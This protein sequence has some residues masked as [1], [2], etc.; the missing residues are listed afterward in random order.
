MDNSTNETGFQLERRAANG[1]WTLLR[2]LPANTTSF[3]D[4]TAL[5]G[6][7]Y[8]YHI[9]ATSTAGNSSWATAT[10]LVHTSVATVNT[11]IWS[12]DSVVFNQASSPSYNAYVP[13][14]FTYYSA[15]SS[16]PFVTGQTLSTTFRNNLSA[17]QGMKITV[18]AAPI[19][20]N[21]LGRWVISGNAGTHTLKLVDAATGVDVPGG[22]VSVAMAGATAGQFQYA[23]LAAP[24]TLAA[25]T[26]YYLVS[27]E[28]SGG[29]QWYE[30]NSA[31]TFDTSMATTQ[32]VSTANN[33][34]NWYLYN[35]NCSFGPLSFKYSVPTAF[36]TG[37]TMTA[38]R[39]DATGWMG[40]KIT[41]GT[42]DLLLNQLGRWVVPGNSGT[43]T[44]KLVN[45]TT[46]VDL[47]SATVAT[48]GATSGQFQYTPLATPIT[49]IASN[50][51]YLLSQETA[52]G[53]QWYDF[54]TPAEGT[55]TGYQFWLLANGLPMDASA[56]GSAAATPANDSLPNLIKYALGLVPNVGGNGGRLSYG[57]VTDTGNNYLS[58]T[59][60][61]PEPA[62][63]GIT[64]TVE[65]SP[66]L[67]SWTTTGLVQMS[68][69]VSASFCTITVRNATP[70]TAGNK[71]FMRLR[72]TQP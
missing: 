4:T 13:T 63:G 40:M 18:K 62:P 12:P 42:S 6:V 59:Y 65:S 26:A 54:A 64:Y 20:I 30:A 37:H 15:S 68:S 60:S 51:Y 71:S 53:D 58:L 55:A 8:E 25:N 1:A 72:T 48:A 11:P 7:I 61:R 52:G 70:M 10:S 5:P 31:L 43:H 9:R 57:Q 24:V 36:V 3:T 22:S 21:E 34:A 44:V 49:L 39:N 41:V 14:G 29:D 32:S 23:T 47:A 50:S 17:W 56:N 69:T 16:I 28:V 33:G 2:T 66:D 46:G 27:Q 19:I 67:T 35:S 45:A 38:L